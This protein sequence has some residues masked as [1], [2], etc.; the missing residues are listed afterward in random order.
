MLTYTTVGP[1]DKGGITIDVPAAFTAPG[2]TTISAD[3]G[4]VST[5]GAVITVSD[6]TLTAGASVKVTY[7]G[8]TAQKTAGEAGFVVKSKSGTDGVLTEL[9]TSPAKVTVGYA[10]SGT[11]IISVSPTTVIQGAT[12]EMAFTYTSIGEV[13]NGSLRISIPEDW[14]V[15]TNLKTKSLDQTAF[16]PNNPTQDRINSAVRS[17]DG[18]TVSVSIPQLSADTSFTVTYELTAPAAKKDNEFKAL[19]Q[20]GPAAQFIELT[21]PSDL[22]KDGE[23]SDNAL[24][25]PT[26][27]AASQIAFKSNPVS[28]LQGV[29]STEIVI[30]TRNDDGGPASPSN[31]LVVTFTSSSETGVFSLAKDG[32]SQNAITVAQGSTTG[33]VYYKD[34]AGSGTATL[35]ATSSIGTVTQEATITDVASKLVLTAKESNYVGDEVTL[36]VET[37]DSAGVVAT[38]VSGVAISLALA[39]GETGTITPATINLASGVTAGSAVLT[40]AAIGS[41]TVTA[42]ATGLTSGTGSLTFNNTVSTVSVSGSPVKAG[43]AITVTATGKPAA[44]ATFSISG[45]VATGVTMTE[46]TTEAGTY[47]GVTETDFSG[48]ADGSYD[49]TVT[50]GAG[51]ESKAG[52][53]VVDNTAPSIASATSDKT[54][55]RNGESLTLTV[56]A[57]AGT[58]VTADVSALDTTQATAVAVAESATAGTYSAEITISSDTTAESGNKKIIVTATDLAGNSSTA[59]VEIA[60]TTYSAFDLVIPKGIGLIH[61]PLSVT[62][63]NGEKKTITTIADLY[64]AI[65]DDKAFLITYDTEAGSWRSYL[66]AN[67]KG[68]ASDVA[69]TDDLGIITVRTAAT[70]AVTVRLKGNALGT[71]GASSMTLKKGKNLVGVPVKDSRIATVGE[72]LS[73]EGV[74]ATSAIVSQEGTFKVLTALDKGQDSDIAITGGQSFIIVGKEDATVAVSGDAWDNVSAVA[75]AAAMSAVGFEVYSQTPVMAIQGSLNSNGLPVETDQFKISLKNVNTGTIHTGSVI[76]NQ[77]KL[78]LVDAVSAKVASVGDVLEISVETGNQQYGVETRRHTVSQTDVT[79]SLL[80]LPELVT[81]EIPAETALLANYPNPF[82]PETWVPFRLAVDS[83][84]QLTIYNSSGNMVRQIDI[85]FKTAAV[86]E[87]KDRAIYWDGRNASGEMVASGVY[88]YTLEA[89][90]YV[91]TRKML[92]LK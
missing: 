7:D 89:G 13:Q 16:D 77:F 55:L 24:I 32:A 56:E 85:G 84:V 88:F 27:P 78:T 18:R 29:S 61:V 37:Q 3:K 57:E 73:L 4:T 5:D 59:E 43:N 69:I 25:V 12:T 66:G 64:D 42:S 39:D 79:S 92:I 9:S 34:A 71:A 22:D 91:S 31:D 68:S 87:T 26:T 76:D 30:E 62:E 41:V 33:S 83:D 6:L 28:M 86:Y 1:M 36:T 10:A 49:V 44:T 67:N 53:V 60:L 21:D 51:S 8:S 72:L 45:D 38:T 58:T 75:T 90:D 47:T 81:Y 2:Q 50:I 74:S 17:T 52:S 20:G 63:V 35:T 15:S 46:S 65:G 54:S 40:G 48:I 82:N 23:T 19:F 70:D 80:S 14:G 11:G